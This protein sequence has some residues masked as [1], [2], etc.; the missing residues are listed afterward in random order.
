[1]LLNDFHKDYVDFIV[2]TTLNF[3][4]KPAQKLTR[5]NWLNS[6]LIRTAEMRLVEY[7]LLLQASVLDQIFTLITGS[8]PNQP[9]AIAT[10]VTK[11]NNKTTVQMFTKKRSKSAVW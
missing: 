7:L 3:G 1:V 9:L 8:D 2:T 11:V 4:Q 5:R 10:I 6:S